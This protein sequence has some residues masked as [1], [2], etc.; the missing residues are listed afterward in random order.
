M[1]LYY[2][3]VWSQASKLD[4]FG[5]VSFF[6]YFSI[7]ILLYSPNF[8]FLSPQACP[9]LSLLLSLTVLYFLP[10][11]KKI[12]STPLVDNTL[13]TLE[14]QLKCHFIFFM[15]SSLISPK[16]G[17]VSDLNCH[18]S[19]SLF[20]LTHG[21]ETWEEYRPERQTELHSNPVFAM[22]WLCDFSEFINLFMPQWR[23]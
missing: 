21:S 4:M 15:I 10:G 3:S 23:K 20:Y 2:R 11:K 14:A 13:S 22:E 8:S 19:F 9:I 1:S 7:I 18:S 6:P 17:A 5:S 12:L 16:L